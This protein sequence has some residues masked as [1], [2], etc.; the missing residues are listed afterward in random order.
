MMDIKNVSS[1]SYPLQG[2]Q[3]TVETGRARA[4]ENV[5]SSSAD[6]LKLSQGTSQVKQTMMTGDD[7]RSDRVEKIQSMLANN[8]YTL[9]GSD[10]LAGAMLREVY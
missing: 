5:A 10:S 1:G 4:E 3:G 6:T 7:I 8:T 2:L 9:P